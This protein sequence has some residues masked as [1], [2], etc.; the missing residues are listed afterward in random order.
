LLNLSQFVARQYW[1]KR[2]ATLHRFR[3]HGMENGVFE[4]GASRSLRINCN[5]LHMLIHG[6]MR[7]CRLLWWGIPGGI[8][9]GPE[10]NE[11]PQEEEPEDARK[12][13]MDNS[14]PQAPLQ[15]LA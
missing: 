10:M 14:H 15:E 1:W 2:W 11:P 4:S 6:A 7:L 9:S 8:N 3:A 13:K 5:H 12:D